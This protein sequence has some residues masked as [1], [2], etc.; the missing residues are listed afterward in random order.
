MIA[1]GVEV[2][3]VASL[4]LASK[5]LELHRLGAKPATDL[6]ASNDKAAALGS[7]KLW[8]RLMP[9]ARGSG[10]GAA[11]IDIGAGV[12]VAEPR[13]G[14]HDNSSNGELEPRQKRMPFATTSMRRAS[15]TGI[16]IS[17]PCIRML[18]QIL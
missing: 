10:K 7:G 18:H 8:V 12:G 17:G 14:R 4:C 3:T 9:V 1:A 15:A 13:Q 11:G 6:D 16:F 2:G 5:V